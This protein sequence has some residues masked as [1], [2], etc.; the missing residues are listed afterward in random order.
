MGKSE[1]MGVRIITDGE[2][3]E[4]VTHRVLEERNIWGTVANLWKENTSREVKM[5]LY[6]RVV[7]PTVV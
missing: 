2:M 5:V 3:G 4:Y 1:Y 6:E 7:I